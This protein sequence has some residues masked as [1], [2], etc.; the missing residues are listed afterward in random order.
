ML[1]T[2]E[3]KINAE[4]TYPIH[5]IIIMRRPEKCFFSQTDR[6]YTVDLD[7]DT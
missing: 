1:G 7:L 6:Y 5:A 2:F 3:S 4:N